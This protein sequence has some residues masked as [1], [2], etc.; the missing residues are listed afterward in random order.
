MHFEVER[1]S[2]RFLVVFLAEN[3]LVRSIV[4]HH[5]SS[6]GAGEDH[7][8]RSLDGTLVTLNHILCRLAKRGSLLAE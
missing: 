8:D 2:Q 6:F 3:A 5:F 7:L 1:V 4:L